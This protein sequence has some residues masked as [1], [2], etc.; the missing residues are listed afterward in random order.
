MRTAGSAFN[1]DPGPDVR[2]R[3]GG[4]TLLRVVTGMIV[5]AIMAWVST[6]QAMPKYVILCIGDG[7]GSEQIRAA[8]MYVNGNPGTLSFEALPHRGSVVTKPHGEDITD[9][10]ASA[11]AMATGTK[12]YNGV[13]SRAIPGGGENLKT[14]LEIA[15][16]EGKAVGVVTTTGVTHATPAAFVAHSR[17][18]R[19]TAEIVEYY[20]RLTRPHVFFG[21]GGT[22][23]PVADTRDAG[24][25]VATTVKDLA[26]LPEENG[27]RVAGLFGS[28]HL[29]YVMDRE[30][31]DPG[32]RQLSAKALAILSQDPDGFFLLIEGGRIDHAG[33]SNDIERLVREVA[34]FSDAVQ[35]VMDWSD[36]RPDTLVLVTA[37]HETGG[38]RVITNRG[39]GKA[40]EVTWQSTGHTSVDVPIFARGSNAFRVNG[41]LDNTDLFD[42]MT[43]R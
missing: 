24:Y 9:S 1:R 8:G 23:I 15:M 20:L 3:F 18:R 2:K 25:R 26:A 32:L 34:E 41:R 17:N 13:I 19:F 35:E 4:A 7:M 31:N 22:E 42:I 30:S 40:P 14:V 27:L 43:N 5:L 11:T 37:D 33:H 36:G 21:G 28:Y 39:A 10:A 16:E 29:P 38:L 6:A 12:V